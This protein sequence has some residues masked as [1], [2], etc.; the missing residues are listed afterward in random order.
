MPG[1]SLPCSGGNSSRIVDGVPNEAAVRSVLIGR[2]LIPYRHYFMGEK[3][4]G[5]MYVESILSTS[6]LACSDLITA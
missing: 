6:L 1:R 5:R 2:K 3:S 4:V